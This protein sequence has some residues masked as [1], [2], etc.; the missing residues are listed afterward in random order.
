LVPSRFVLFVNL[1]SRTL[2][3][4]LKP[5]HI[6]EIIVNTVVDASGQPVTDGHAGVP[7]CVHIG[8][9]TDEKLDMVTE[10]IY[11]YTAGIPRIVYYALTTLGSIAITDKSFASDKNTLDALMRSDVKKAIMDASLIVLPTSVPLRHIFSTLLFFSVFFPFLSL[12]F[13]F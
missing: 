3:D 6:R 8:T 2:T 9:D 11:L 12:P 5:K 4:P 1:L 10:V 13:V 7:L